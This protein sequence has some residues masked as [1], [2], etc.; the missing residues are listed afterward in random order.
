MKTMRILSVVVAFATPAM[1]QAQF[2]SFGLA[3]GTSVGSNAGNGGNTHANV[4]L[5]VKPPLLPGIRGE[6]FVIDAKSPDGKLAVVGNVVLSAPIPVVT[7]YLIGGWGTYGIGGDTSK[8]GFNFG[9]GARASVVVGP[10][11]Y[12]EIRR[13]DPWARNLVTVGVQF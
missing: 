8:Q 4:S 13:H 10:A 1:A 9:V 3:A 11:F 12:V 6:A 2:I 7:P 5:E